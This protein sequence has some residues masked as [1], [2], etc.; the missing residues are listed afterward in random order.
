[1]YRVLHKL[2]LSYLNGTFHYDVD[3]TLG[4]RLNLYHLF[5]PRVRTTLAKNFFTSGERKF[6]IH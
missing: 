6:E 1:M 5:V 3:I 4:T 2:S